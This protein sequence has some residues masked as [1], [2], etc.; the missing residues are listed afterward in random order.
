M[1]PAA[2][3]VNISFLRPKPKWFGARLES[4]MKFSVIARRPGL[5]LADA[6]IYFL[7]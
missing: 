1:E 2:R 7:D 5:W 4:E 3:Q 6:A